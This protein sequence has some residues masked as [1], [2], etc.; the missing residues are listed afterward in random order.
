MPR[1][2]NI[3]ASHYPARLDDPWE[4][5]SLYIAEGYQKYCMRGFEKLT[6]LLSFKVRVVK[7]N[8]DAAARLALPRLGS[9]RLDLIFNGIYISSPSQIYNASLQ[10]INGLCSQQYSGI[11]WHFNE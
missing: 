1:E 7:G 10:N 5:E 8:V 6:M 11:L 9:A 2:V 4:L 3:L